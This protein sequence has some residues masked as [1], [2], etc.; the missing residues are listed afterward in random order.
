M[1]IVQRE[2]ADAE[3][4]VA[5]EE[6]PNVR[7]T[8]ATAGDTFAAFVERQGVVPVFCPLDVEA[9]GDREDGSV[10]SHARRGDAVEHV[11]S[12]ADALDQVSGESDTHEVARPCAG[13]CLVDDVEHLV[14]RGLLLADRE[15]ANCEPV[16]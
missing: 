15:P 9:A 10:S 6:M 8:E 3:Y 11:D 2:Q 1:Y 12:A 16:P 5:H 13:Q 7:A 14:H 4:L